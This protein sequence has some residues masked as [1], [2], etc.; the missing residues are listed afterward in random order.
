MSRSEE[1]EKE[2][3]SA[4]EFVLSPEASPTTGR[5]RTT[6]AS[7]DH[8]SSPRREQDGNQNEKN[9]FERRNGKERKEKEVSFD[10]LSF[11]LLRLVSPPARTHQSR[12]Y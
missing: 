11:S 5:T 2:G 10:V 8:G 4:P 12:A 9:V 3:R 7:S 6:R 1:V